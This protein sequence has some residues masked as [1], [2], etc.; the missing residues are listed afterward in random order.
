MCI[1]VDVSTVILSGFCVEDY[2][3]RAT[4]CGLFVEG[5]N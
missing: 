3:V 5:Y 1:E 2:P 4:D